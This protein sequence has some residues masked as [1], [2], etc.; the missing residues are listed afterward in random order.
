MGDVSLEPSGQA[1]HS[2][3]AVW[4]SQ[5][6][7]LAS[8]VTARPG[9]SPHRAG[10]YTTSSTSLRHKHSARGQAPVR[11]RVPRVEP[12]WSNSCLPRA[13]RVVSAPEEQPPEV[14]ALS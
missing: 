3:A 2:S 8:V 12:V 11:V 9:Y 4:D 6:L 14:T 7:R 10:A 1:H 13:A 5:V